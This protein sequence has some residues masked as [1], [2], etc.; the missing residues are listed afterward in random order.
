MASYPDLI[1]TTEAAAL[2]G[3]TVQQ[4]R[5][6]ADA[7]ELSRVARGLVERASVDR[8]LVERRGGRT[9]VWSEYVAWGAIAMLSGQ[10]A[11][12]LTAT[13]ASRVRTALCAMADPRELVIRTRGRATTLTYAGDTDA[14]TRLREQLANPNSPAPR[15]ITTQPDHLDGYLGADALTRLEVELG[16]RRDSLGSRGDRSAGCHDREV[17]RGK[18]L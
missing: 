8:Y 1:S 15:R 16:L 4:V 13:Q 18:A 7:G 10:A 6:L 17:D 12:W 11:E 9:R 14:A 5:R 2:L 3:I